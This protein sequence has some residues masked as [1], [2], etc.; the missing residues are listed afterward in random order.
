M[1]ETWKNIAGTNYSVSDHGRIKNDKTGVILKPFKVGDKKRSNQYLAVDI[2]GKTVKVHRIVAQVF[3]SN[4]EGKREVNHIDGDHFNN[5]LSNLEWVS[6]SENCI[7]AY[8][9][10]G[11]EKLIGGKNPNSK[12]II[13]VED[14]KLFDSLAEATRSCGLK[15]HAPISDVLR[16][17]REK[18]GGYR[19]RYQNEQSS[20]INFDFE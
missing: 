7:H 6:G 3:L 5:D 8:S 11:K 4:P 10:L 2:H 16:G 9:V 20:V 13:R 15:S 14:G 18:A 19:W 12:K 17:K 1:I